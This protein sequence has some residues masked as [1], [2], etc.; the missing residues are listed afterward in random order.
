M[1]SIGFLVTI[2]LLFNL[3]NFILLVSVLA[4]L[5]RLS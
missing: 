1:W 2:N 4:R 3:V 5:R